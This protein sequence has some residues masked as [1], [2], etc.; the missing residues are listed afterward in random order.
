MALMVPHSNQLILALP[1][2]KGTEIAKSAADLILVDD[3]LSK[4]I[5]AVAAGRRIYN[6]KKSSAVYCFYSYSY[7]INRFL[8]FIFLGWRYPDILLC[9]CYFSRISDG[10][11]VFQLFTKMNLPK[12]KVCSNFLDN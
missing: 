6:L 7:Y 12:K 3:D 10:T 8:T 1:W 2:E 11:H 9:S 5:V 4:M